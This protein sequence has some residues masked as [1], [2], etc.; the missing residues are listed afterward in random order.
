MRP[1]LGDHLAHRAAHRA[2]VVHV[3]RDRVDRKLLGL[4]RLRQFGRGGDVADSGVHS[5]AKAPEVERRGEADAG[6][7]T[8]NE[9]DGHGDLPGRR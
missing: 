9:D 6:A 2:L 3:E 5:V 4:D 7:A 8:R 1:A